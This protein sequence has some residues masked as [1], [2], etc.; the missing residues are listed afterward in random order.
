MIFW[1]AAKGKGKAQHKY[2]YQISRQ[3]KQKTE[4]IQ[5]PENSSE[6]E[7]VQESFF[8]QHKIKRREKQQ[9]WRHTTNY[10]CVCVLVCRTQRTFDFACNWAYER[11]FCI[12]ALL[13]HKWKSDEGV[14][15]S[16]EGP[17]PG[18]P[19]WILP[20][21]L[22]LPCPRLVLFWLQKSLLK[23]QALLTLLQ[24]QKEKQI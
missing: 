11:D 9:K 14:G 1:K 6:R 24:T 8:P 7:S 13:G 10:M 2:A 3:R 18:C 4:K 17:G 12:W 19:V 21:C 23:F 16:T 22:Y 5:Q 15:Y 20:S